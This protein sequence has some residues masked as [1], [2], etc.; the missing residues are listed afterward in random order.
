MYRPPPKY[1]SNMTL[2]PFRTPLTITVVVT[3]TG[4]TFMPVQQSR[5][6]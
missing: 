6:S 3:V 2:R 4:M 1:L 5:M